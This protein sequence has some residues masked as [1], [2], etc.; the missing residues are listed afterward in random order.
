MEQ[1]IE[2]TQSESITQASKTEGEIGF[3]EEN[4]QAVTRYVVVDIN[5]NLYGMS[6][7]TTV[8][9]MSSQMT[10]VTRVPHSPD[11][12]SGVINHRGTIIPVIDMRSL[13]GFEPLSVEAERLTAEFAKMKAGHVDW[14]KALHDTI[15]FGTKFTKEI[16]PTQCA[17]GKWISSV[18]N[19]NSSISQ[20]ANNDPILKTIIERFDEPHRRIHGVAEK[21][22]AFKEL[23]EIEKAQ[24]LIDNARENDIPLLSDLFDQVLSEISSKLESM[25]VITEIDSSKAAIAVDGVSFVIDCNNDS[26]EPLPETAENTEFLSGLVHQSDGTYILIADLAHIYKTACPAQ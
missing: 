2:Q 12:I 18:L 20:M 3:N 14:I 22:L 6:T 4:N 25:L 19:G 1:I 15:A 10:Q 16:D 24:E 7:D 17:L 11:Y 23:G 9:L 13:L 26:V 5:H 21:A 8:E